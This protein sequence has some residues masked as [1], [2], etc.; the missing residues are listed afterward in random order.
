MIVA[1]PSRNLSVSSQGYCAN[2]LQCNIS[3]I[4][5]MF[6][7]TFDNFIVKITVRNL[8]IIELVNDKRLG[9]GLSLIHI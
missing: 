7:N 5:Q 6:Q 3:L 8:L 4:K 9:L 2:S 1:D